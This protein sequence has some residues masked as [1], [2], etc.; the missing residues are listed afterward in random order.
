MIFDLHIHTTFSDGDYT[1]S[2]I[3]AMA[4]TAGL[5][6]IAIT[7]HDECRGYGD[8]R[9]Y[10]NTCI[11]RHR[12]GG[13]TY[14]S[15]VHVLGLMIDWQNASALQEH[16]MKHVETKAAACAARCSRN[17]KKRAWI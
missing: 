12:A 3:A 15:E 14:T 17:C 7:D 5:D 1:P 2:E 6:G 13:K 11:C 8:I 10:Q 4:E 16:A 9:E